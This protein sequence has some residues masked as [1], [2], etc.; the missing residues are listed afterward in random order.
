M[1]NESRTDLIDYLYYLL[2]DKVTKNVYPMGVPTELTA[3]DKK[4]GFIVI[5]LGNINDESEFAKQTFGWIRC[6]FECYVPTL[7]RGRFN[8]KAYKAMQDAVI[9]VI[10]ETIIDSG[11]T[12]YS[13]E[14][15]SV[16]SYDDDDHGNPDNRFFLF[17]KSFI[18]TIDSDGEQPNE[19]QE[20]NNN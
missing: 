13:I 20:N 16:L 10:N 8:K 4:D 5:R 3:S 17:V 7:T 6:Y 2:Y 12:V 11:S 15:D 14:D 19:Q 18:V 1:V 9:A